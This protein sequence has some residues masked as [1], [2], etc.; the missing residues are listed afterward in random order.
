MYKPDHLAFPWLPSFW[1]NKAA[2]SHCGGVGD[3]CDVCEVVPA[4][5]DSCLVPF[6][7][8]F[9]NQWT[10]KED[11]NRKMGINPSIY[12]RNTN[13]WRTRS[14][15]CAGLIWSSQTHC[16]PQNGPRYSGQGKLQ[17]TQRSIIIARLNF[18]ISDSH[19]IRFV[20]SQT[21][22]TFMN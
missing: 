6:K 9:V 13:I 4:S 10:Q 12:L 2:K 7:L 19:S 21:V 8:R 18:W 11:S 14:L 16:G 22:W 17:L 5:R 15:L 1:L 3:Y 20:S